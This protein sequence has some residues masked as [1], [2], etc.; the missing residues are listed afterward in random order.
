MRGGH[1]RPTARR[2]VRRGAAGWAWGS[3]AALD[4]VVKLVPFLIVSCEVCGSPTLTD[5]IDL[6][7]LVQ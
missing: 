6:K 4:S 7:Q 3:A 1:V 5:V 2:G